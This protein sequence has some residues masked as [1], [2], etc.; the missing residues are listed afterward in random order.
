MTPQTHRVY[1]DARPGVCTSLFL[2]PESSLPGRLG[3]SYSLLSTGWW[4]PSSPP[5]PGEAPQHDPELLKHFL[6]ARKAELKPLHIWVPRGLQWWP[7]SLKPYV[8]PRSSC[9][10]CILLHCI[11]LCVFIS[12]SMLIEVVQC[13]SCVFTLPL[14]QYLTHLEKLSNRSLT[15][16]KVILDMFTNCQDL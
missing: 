7:I 11:L 14:S 2:F 1:K 6:P 15:F 8:S 3:G 9:D 10:F 16:Q 13:F 4:L 5:H 12:K